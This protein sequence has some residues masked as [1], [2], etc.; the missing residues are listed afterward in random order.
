MLV[1]NS[2][3]R[4][5]ANWKTNLRYFR[6][7]FELGFPHLLHGIPQQ[8]QRLDYKTNKPQ[9]NN[10]FF[11]SN[12]T[13]L[14]ISQS[15]GSQVSGLVPWLPFSLKSLITLLTSSELPR[16]KTSLRPFLSTQL[17]ASGSPGIM[18]LMTYITESSEFL[19]YLHNVGGLISSLDGESLLPFFFLFG[20]KLC[21]DVLKSGVG[22]T[23][24][25]PWRIWTRNND[26]NEKDRCIH[27]K[28]T[29]KSV[30]QVP[31][32]WNLSLEIL[33][34]NWKGNRPTQ[35]SVQTKI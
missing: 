4:L 10:S 19:L 3:T 31:V 30:C 22:R 1:E 7:H 13:S 12:L 16:F 26:I 15:L 27:A 23:Y 18:T 17:I 33:A 6:K 20:F 29:L 21:F 5:S 25:T 28:N 35:S 8:L 2:I 14:C 34:I 11:N 9:K 32:S 24:I